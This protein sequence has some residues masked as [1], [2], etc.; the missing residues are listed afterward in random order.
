MTH[1]QILKTPTD[2]ENAILFQMV[3]SITQDGEQ[4]EIGQI[5]SQSH[6]CIETT[7]AFYYKNACEFRVCTLVH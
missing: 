5:I 2:F 3:I 1:G 4:M 7:N 6:H